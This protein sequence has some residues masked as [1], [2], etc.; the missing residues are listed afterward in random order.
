MQR[1]NI[2]KIDWK[3][4]LIKKKCGYQ[5]VLS[6]KTLNKQNLNPIFFLGQYNY[7]QAGAELC[8]AQVKL[9]FIFQVVEEAGSWSCNLSLW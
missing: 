4:C 5:G 2:Y 1:K 8:Q 3:E 9:E 6:Q 7:K